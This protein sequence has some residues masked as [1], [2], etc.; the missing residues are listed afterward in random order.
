MQH[1]GLVFAEYVVPDE[2]HLYS[3]PTPPWRLSFLL[4]DH[5]IAAFVRHGARTAV[6]ARLRKTTV[7][8]PGNSLRDFYLIE[9][10]SHELGHHL[11]QHNAGKRTAQVRRRRDHERF[12]DLHSRRTYVDLL[13]RGSR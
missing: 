8:W 3:V 7:E 9:V 6:D 10:L 13:S 1:I 12:A 4:S 11:L 5:D 2:I